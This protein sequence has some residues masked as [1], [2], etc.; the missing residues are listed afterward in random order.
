MFAGFTLF[1]VLDR[2]VRKVGIEGFGEYSPGNPDHEERRTEGK[3]LIR[4]GASHVAC[5]ARVDAVVKS[6][7]SCGRSC[8]LRVTVV[9]SA[10]HRCLCLPHSS[11]PSVQASRPR[12]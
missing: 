12:S 1:R 4:K 8:A 6:F 5:A 7:H 9:T 3:E 10:A 11:R 2:I